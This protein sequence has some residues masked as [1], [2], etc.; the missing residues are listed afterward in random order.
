MFTCWMKGFELMIID[1]TFAE[2]FFT[3]LF[4]QRIKSLE[5]T[6]DSHTR[7][8][9]IGFIVDKNILKPPDWV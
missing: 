8:F 9:L 7:D 1:F 3:N 5:P 2:A 6:R 4:Y